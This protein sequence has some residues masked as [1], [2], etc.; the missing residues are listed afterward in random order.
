MLGLAVLPIVQE[1]GLNPSE[2]G[3][4]RSGFYLLFAL[5]CV[6]TGFVSNHVRT[7]WGLAETGGTQDAW[8]TAFQSFG[9]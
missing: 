1:I 5:S 2:F 8:G 7:K 3:L 9:G 6:V 4:L